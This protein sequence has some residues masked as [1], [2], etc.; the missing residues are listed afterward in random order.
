M[1]VVELAI[2]SVMKTAAHCHVLDG[3]QAVTLRAGRLWEIVPGDIATIAVAKRWVYGGRPYFSGTI[4]SRRLE[5]GA[6]GLTPLRLNPQGMWD[7]AGEYWGEDEAPIEP[8]ARKIIKRGP[9]PAFEMEQVIPGED[10]DDPHTDPIIESNDRKDAGDFHGAYDILMTLCRADLR[11]LDAHAHLGNLSFHGSPQDAIRNYEA[12]VRIGELSLGE[13]FDGVLPWG[14]INNRP[15][16]RCLRGYG[17]CLW[18]LGRFEECANTF[19]RLLSLNPPGNQGIRFMIHQV[20]ARKTW[21][22]CR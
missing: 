2:L 17:L 8:W 20:R 13:P 22:D 18:R 11:C 12:G 19:E 9:R 3:G 16:L 14:D 1:N 10:P 7:P 5:A 15:F 21:E 6:L 4:E